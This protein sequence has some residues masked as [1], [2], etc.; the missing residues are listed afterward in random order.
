MKYLALILILLS[1]SLYADEPSEEIVAS[2]SVVI[3]EGNLKLSLR[4]VPAAIIKSDD[5]VAGALT[6]QK[7]GEE[8]LEA[9]VGDLAFLIGELTRDGQ[10]VSGVQFE[11]LFHH[12][13]DGKDVFKTVFA[14]KDGKFNWGQQFFDG[15]EHKVVLKARPLTEGSFKPIKAEM[16]VGVEGLDPPSGV[17]IKSMA[18]LL[19]ICAVAMIVGYFFGFK[20]AA[21][22][23]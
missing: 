10:A 9:R 18:F 5:L 22:K 15:A 6:A 16:V 12:I 17:V 14:S 4:L 21:A 2:D 1:F 19:I 11:L 13:E 7:E 23:A 3:S 8:I 20:S